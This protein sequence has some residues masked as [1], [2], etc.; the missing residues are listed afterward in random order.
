MEEHFN[1]PENIGK[2]GIK[3]EGRDECRLQC[4]CSRGRDMD[5]MG[6]GTRTGERQRTMPE[7]APVPCFAHEPA[8]CLPRAWSVLVPATLRRG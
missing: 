2:Q 7:A 1:I 3:D 6:E 8:F 4:S 5:G